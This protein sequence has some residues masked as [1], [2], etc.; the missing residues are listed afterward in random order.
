MSF[1]D[2]VVGPNG[3]GKS[4]LFARVIEPAR[5]GLPFVNADLIAAA[6]FGA[7]AEARSYEA[8]EIA[9]RTREALIDARLDFC[10]ETVF[11]HASKLELIETALD[12]EY[13]VTVHVVMVPVE[14]SSR[15]VLAR[16]AAGGHSVPEE[17]IRTR[18]ERLWPNVAAIVP[19][20]HQTVFWDNADD[21]GPRRL[22]TFRRGLPDFR[23]TWPA[24]CPPVIAALGAP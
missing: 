1:L 14:L 19:V 22:A 10:A 6:R 20:T 3:A 8:A 5:P 17:K 13:H 12:A 9:A 24:W 15:R 21:A 7:D 11:S 23:P 4:T 18:F 2:L 16:V